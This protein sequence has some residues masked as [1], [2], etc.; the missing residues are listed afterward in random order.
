MPE[1]RTSVELEELYEELHRTCVEAAE[2]LRKGRAAGYPDVDIL[3]QFVACEERAK[4]TW[5][6][7]VAFRKE[8]QRRAFTLVGREPARVPAAEG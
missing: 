5:G 6:Q 7:I 1:V 3:K 2:A 4:E 8:D